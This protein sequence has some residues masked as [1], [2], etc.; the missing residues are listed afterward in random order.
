[1]EENKTDIATMQAKTPAKAQP[2]KAKVAALIEQN[3][4]KLLA[5]MPRHMNTERLL[6]VMT[7]AVTSTPAL[8]ECYVPS[9][10]GSVMQLAQMGLEPNTVLGHAYLIPFNNKKKNRTDVQ[11]IIGYK[12]LID[13]ARRSGHIVS[14]AAH[15]VYSNDLFEFEY[16][17]T[18]KLRHV[19]GMGDRGAITHFYAVAMLKDGGHAF[20]VMS[21][22]DVRKVRAGTQGRS[23]SVWDDH[24]EQMGR[25]TALR[26]LMK[27]LPLSVEMA[28]AGALE[29]AAVTGADQGLDAALDGEWNPIADEPEA[30]AIENAPS[31]KLPQQE[32]KDSIKAQAAVAKAHELD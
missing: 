11:V 25:K 13:L 2:P 21:V 8:M 24:F 6:R 4:G 9:L 3:K 29:E 19:P 14:I 16:G 1:M 5:A 28:Q 12:G 20:E 15:A 23:N 18:E 17:L 7:T 27:Y 22:D 30:R 32:I 26:R 10:L 31:E